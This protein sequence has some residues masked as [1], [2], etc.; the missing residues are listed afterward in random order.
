MREK[1]AQRIVVITG[2]LV[3]VLAIVFARIQN[4]ATPLREQDSTM[5]KSSIELRK[6]SDANPKAIEAG[7]LIYAQQG[8]ARCHSID[9]RGNQRNPLDN[10]GH[11]RSATELR[12]WVI[13]DDAIKG[14]LP[15]S[16]FRLK[17][18]YGELPSED[19]DTLIVYLQ[20]L[21]Q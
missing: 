20:S 7:R 5:K 19:L 17:K 10:V 21:Q 1:W 18:K 16:V 4:P 15:E 3:L 9:G 8:C 11:T 12:E 13:G 6:S 2:L 14:M